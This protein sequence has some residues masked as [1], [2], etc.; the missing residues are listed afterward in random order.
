MT[1]AWAATVRAAQLELIITIDGKPYGRISYGNDYPG[2]LAL[3]DYRPTCHDCSVKI[4]Q[5]HIPG[6]DVERCPKCGG[7]A[8]SCECMPEVDGQGISLFADE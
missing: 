8:I 3:V 7:Q 4:G 6:C 2:M 5:L 1:K